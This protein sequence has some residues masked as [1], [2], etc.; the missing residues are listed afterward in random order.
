MTLPSDIRSNFSSCEIMKNSTVNVR[1][2]PQKHMNPNIYRYIIS[3]IGSKKFTLKMI[4][5]LNCC[6]KLPY[7]AG[8]DGNRIV[9]RY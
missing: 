3:E 7:T 1:R 8:C 6:G 9:P 2:D 5:N 4:Q